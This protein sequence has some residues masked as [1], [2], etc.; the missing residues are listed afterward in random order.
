MTGGQVGRIIE[1]SFDKSGKINHYESYAEYK[2]LA[3]FVKPGN[4]ASLLGIKS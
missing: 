2:A 4:H 3:S 1:A